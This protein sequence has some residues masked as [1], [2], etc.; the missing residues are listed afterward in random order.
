MPLAD[1]LVFNQLLVLM[2]PVFINVY[3]S[4]S[5]TEIGWFVPLKL[6]SIT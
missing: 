5:K 1:K 2:L 4:Q 6:A 3:T